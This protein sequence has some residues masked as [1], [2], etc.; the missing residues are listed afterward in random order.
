LEYLRN[1]HA[2]ILKQLRSG[3]IDDTITNVLENV[4]KEISARFK[5]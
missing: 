4:A 5:A 3:I 1:K 2:D